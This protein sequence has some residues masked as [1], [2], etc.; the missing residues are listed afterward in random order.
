MDRS[1][2]MKVGAVAGACA[3]LGA[4][5]GIVGSAAS[6]NSDSDSKAENRSRAD[7]GGP[8]AFL[9]HRRGPDL[10][11]GGPPVHSESVVPNEDGDGF[12]TI[13]SDTGRSSRCPGPSSR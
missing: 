3:V 10:G 9:R 8:P 12:E 1:G 7:A 13:T 5:G 2:W 6:P 11:V 4:A